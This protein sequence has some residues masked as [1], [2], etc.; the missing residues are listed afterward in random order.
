MLAPLTCEIGSDWS[1]LFDQSDVM[2]LLLFR[3]VNLLV[4]S[5]ILQKYSVIQLFICLC[6]LE[7]IVRVFGDQ[8][9]TYPFCMV[10]HSNV[11][12]LLPIHACLQLRRATARNWK[13]GQFESADYRI[14]KR[15][16]WHQF[17]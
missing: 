10:S 17:V 4:F 6:V 11:W 7:V 5:I 15:Y 14:S 3:G 1:I 13:T 9:H 16:P 12:E 8:G 2:T